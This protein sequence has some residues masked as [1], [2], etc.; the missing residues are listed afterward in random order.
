[1]PFTYRLTPSGRARQRQDEARA[2]S[3]LIA[4]LTGTPHHA[5]VTGLAIAGGGGAIAGVNTA[6]P[7]YARWRSAHKRLT[8]R[9][10]L[11]RQREQ[12][13]A[14]TGGPYHPL[15]PLVPCRV[16]PALV[17]R[18]T[19]R[20]A[21]L[22]TR[23]L[24]DYGGGT[25]IQAGGIPA[26]AR[27]ATIPQLHRHLV[28]VLNAI[29]KEL[30]DVTLH[31]EDH[32]L[33]AAGHPPLQVLL[34]TEWYYRVPGR[35]LRQAEH[36]GIITTLET[37]SAK[38]PEWLLVP[39]SI[40]WTPDPLGNARLRV[41][42]EAPVLYGGA[43]IAR[44][45]KREQHDID[46]SPAVRAIQR[47][48]PDEPV[49][50]PGYVT[51]LPIVPTQALCSFLHRGRTFCVEICRDQ[52]VGDAVAGY[53]ALGL[54]GANVY[55]FTSN[56]TVLSPGFLPVVNN[57]LAVWCDGSGGGA[58]QYH[59]VTRANPLTHNWTPGIHPLVAYR[60]AFVTT[61]D[62]NVLSQE[63]LSEG[64]RIEQENQPG[65]R[66]FMAWF[67]G[68]FGAVSTD[69]LYRTAID[70]GLGP[71]S[72]NALVQPFHRKGRRIQ[73]I[74][75]HGLLPG[76]APIP[77]AQVAAITPYGNALVQFAT[78]DIAQSATAGAT[79][80]AR[81]AAETGFAVVATPVGAPIVP[82]PGFYDLHLHDLVDL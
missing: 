7:L 26:T 8:R 42:N 47:W 3:L 33:R 76:G 12:Q 30:L 44:R 28:K 80:L 43:V 75:G 13:A 66:A 54:P 19:I 74:L 73:Q 46:S 56:G 67:D 40:F 32:D 18:D 23:T 41:Y 31:R 45:T 81:T 64:W 10:R 52:H 39:G 78:E 11:D 53:L 15:H 14:L 82:V 5:A 17:P 71:L 68:V 61:R 60:A 36:D 55:L 21:A 51:P 20:L 4:A 57:G 24:E 22:T 38:Y 16:H 6:S 65:Y 49:A 37:I 59:R 25:M 29:E 79:G 58:Y 48:G 35:P 9:A 70:A 2:W 72:P 50:A 1:M 27:K 34:A 77:A 63:G 62:H 69:P